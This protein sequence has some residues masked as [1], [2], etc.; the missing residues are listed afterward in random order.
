MIQVYDE[1]QAYRPFTFDEDANMTED[2]LTFVAIRTKSG[3]HVKITGT[4]SYQSDRI[5]IL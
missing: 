3:Y 1:S 5:K 2:G 4:C